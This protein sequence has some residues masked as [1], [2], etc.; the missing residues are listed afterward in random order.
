VHVL[1]HVGSSIGLE[2][3]LKKSKLLLDCVLIIT[4]VVPPELPME[5]SLAVNTSLAALAKFGESITRGSFN[6]HLR[7]SLAI[8]CTEPFRIPY[9]GRVDVCCF[10]K[11][12]T[13]TAENLVVEGVVGVEFVPIFH[14]LSVVLSVPF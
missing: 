14:Y 11:T 1:I 5:L 4:S 6:T 9:A 13:I 7:R 2:R 10:D 3:G 8:F 12:G